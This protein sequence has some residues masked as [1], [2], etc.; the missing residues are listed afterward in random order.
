[1]TPRLTVELELALNFATLTNGGGV[2][3]WMRWPGW[4]LHVGC[5]RCA[6]DGK[7][8]PCWGREACHGYDTGCGC[9]ACAQRQA[10]AEARF[11]QG[12][13]LGLGGTDVGVLR[14]ELAAIDA[15]IEPSDDR[16]AG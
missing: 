3:P 14:A 6:G 11:L 4:V 12:A 2:R 13:A 5:D 7:A 16:R 9:S 1:M 10:F 8:A 15:Q